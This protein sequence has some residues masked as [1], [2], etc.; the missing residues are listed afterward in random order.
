MCFCEGEEDDD[1]G[2]LPSGRDGAGGP[3]V[4]IREPNS[5]PMVTSC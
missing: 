2:E 1:V 3:T 5:T 4:T